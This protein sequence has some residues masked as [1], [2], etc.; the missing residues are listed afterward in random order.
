MKPAREVPLHPFSAVPPTAITFGEA[1]GY[2]APCPLSPAEAVQKVPAWLM[3][4]SQAVSPLTCG[5]I[6]CALADSGSPAYP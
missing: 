2:S 5:A 4:P 1:A 6:P 3:P